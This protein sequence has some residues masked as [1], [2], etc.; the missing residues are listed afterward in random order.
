MCTSGRPVNVLENEGI[1]YQSL[2]VWTNPFN[3]LGIDQEEIN[4]RFDNA[5]SALEESPPI[6][7]EEDKEIKENHQRIRM[8]V[9]KLKLIR[10]GN[11]LSLVELQI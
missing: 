5:K 9:I 1:N 10:N 7:N 8:K 2:D 4:F 6:S 3:E 11:E